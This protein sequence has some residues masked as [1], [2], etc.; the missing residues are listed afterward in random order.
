MFVWEYQVVIAM[1][2]YLA[3]I[4]SALYLVIS[5]NRPYKW[6]RCFLLLLIPI[7]GVIVV[8]VDYFT[9]LKAKVTA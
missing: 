3:I 9:H 1:I 6:L 5:D 8:A 2:I 4:S 7:I